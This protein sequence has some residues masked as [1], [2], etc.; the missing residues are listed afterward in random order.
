MSTERLHTLAVRAKNGDTDALEELLRDQ[1]IKHVIYN[2]ANTKVGNADADDIYQDVRLKIFEKIHTWQERA[3]ITSWVGTITHNACFDFLRKTKPDRIIVTAALPE[4][5][6]DAPQI[7]W[8]ATQQMTA[9]THNAIQKL[10][11]M[12]RQFMELYI[13]EGLDK[14]EIM[15]RLSVSRSAF[16]R[17]WNPCYNALLRTIQKKIRKKM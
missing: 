15:T 7:Q 11:G 13:V 6:V 17:K 8:L 1:E 16:Y 9:I 3:K 5:P 12:C 4:M 10:E 2:I 14:K